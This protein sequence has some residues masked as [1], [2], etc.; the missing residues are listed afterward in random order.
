MPLKI[1]TVPQNH[2]A[3]TSRPQ[4]REACRTIPQARTQE[5]RQRPSPW[6]AASPQPVRRAAIA[7]DV[8]R[9][10]QYWCTYPWRAPACRRAFVPVLRVVIVPPICCTRPNCRASDQRSCFATSNGRAFNSRAIGCTAHR[11]SQVTYN[12]V[13]MHRIPAG[14]SRPPTAPHWHVLESLVEP[15]TPSLRPDPA[16]F[17]SDPALRGLNRQPDRP[18]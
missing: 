11:C 1:D 13:P 18:P 10:C 15:H 6:R 4:P 16:T 3:P 12:T 5:R 17:D 2:G 14:S 7:A 9:S 8:R